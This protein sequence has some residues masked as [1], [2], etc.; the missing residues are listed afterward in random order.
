MK[1]KSLFVLLSLST[2]LTIAG[3]SGNS[4]SVP[5]ASTTSNPTK[6]EQTA[7]AQIQTSGMSQDQNQTK[8]A[9]PAKQSITVEPQQKAAPSNTPSSAVSSP[10]VTKASKAT[11]P[12]QPTAKAAHPAPT[13]APATNTKP[14]VQQTISFTIIGADHKTIVPRIDVPIQSDDTVL[15]ILKEITREKGI[16]MEYRGSG[17]AAYVEG[18]D[19]VYEFDQGPKSGWMFRVNG[20]FGDRSCGSYAVHAGDV[21]QWLYSTNLGKDLGK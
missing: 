15:S 16:Q 1:K 20:N 14:P 13:A 6:T 4:S 21:I 17:A 11:T 2:L 7:P 12:A 18:I 19:N 10:T 8:P 9:S 5:A 3:C